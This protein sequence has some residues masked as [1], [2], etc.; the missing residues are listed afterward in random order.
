MK[1]TKKLQAELVEF[2]RIYRKPKQERSLTMEEY[3]NYL[4]GR[5][6]PG[7]KVK[8][9]PKPLKAQSIPSWAM[10]PYTIPSAATTNH[11][12]VKNSIMDRLERESKEVKE[13][14]LRK[15]NQIAIP[16]S[17]GAYQFISDKEMAKCLGRK[18]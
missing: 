18:L 4:Y 6:L 16:Y 2:N 10:D 1:I 8:S 15:K 7:M 12:P 14:I 13:E 11:I 17:K 9:K 3:I 5:G